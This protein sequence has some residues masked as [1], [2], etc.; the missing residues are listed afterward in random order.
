[1]SWIVREMPTRRSIA[2]AFPVPTRAQLM[3]NLL[4]INCWEGRV[5]F[6]ICMEIL[7]HQR[8]AVHDRSRLNASETQYKWSRYGAKHFSI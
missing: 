7:L 1:M 3:I 4:L 5:R 2:R 6:K 8:N